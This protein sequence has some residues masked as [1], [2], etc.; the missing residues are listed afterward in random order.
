MPDLEVESLRELARL[1]KVLVLGIGG[2]GDSLGALQL[3]M[4]LRSLGGRPILGS[5][6]WER[7]PQDPFP[8]PIP[9][10]QLVNGEVLGRSVA[11]VNPE[12][13]VDRYGLRVRPQVVSASIALGEKTV[14]VDVSKGAAGMTEALEIVKGVLEV[15]AVVGVDVG[16]DVVARGCEEDLWSPLADAVSLAALNRSTV[17]SLIYL[18]SPGADGELSQGEVLRNVSSI[19][20]RGG[21]VGVF[22]LEK[23]EYDMLR[24]VEHLFYSEASK[25]PL[26]AFEGR[27]GAVKI[28]RGSREVEVTP[29]SATAYMLRTSS[30]YSH[31]LTAKLAED[32]KSIDQARRRL[33]SACIYTELDL[34]EDLHK[35]KVAYEGLKVVDIRSRGRQR[36]LLSGCNPIS[37][38]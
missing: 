30:V 22:G 31:S 14:F 3:Y 35:L 16:G 13:Y 24:S 37:C 19:A 34:E 8:G 15:E 9:V 2:G 10:E 33:N 27:H 11:L 32:T 6:V 26:R 23:E 20:R 38:T 4:K 18:L 36:L 25:I 28:R 21:L 7:M 5:I 17:P 29:A 1:G 12:S